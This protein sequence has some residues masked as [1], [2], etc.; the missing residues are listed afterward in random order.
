MRRIRAW[1][2][3]LSAMFRRERADHE[4]AAELDAHLQLHIEDNLR[5]GL[6]PAEAR[7]QALLALGGIET[8]K[9]AWRDRRGLPFLDTIAQD[10]RF[11]YRLLAKSPGFT[12]VAVCTLA[13]GIGANTAIFSVIDAVMLQSLPV[14]DPQHLFLL[15]W[16]AR[17]TPK[18]HGYSSYGDCASGDWH[19]RVEGCSLSRPFLDDVRNLGVFS[20]L[21]EFAGGN[22]VTLSGNGPATRVNAQFVSGDYFE[23]LGIAPAVGR[24]FVPSDDVPG[25]AAVAV[26]HYGYWQRQYGGDPSVVGRTVRLNG[27]PFTI[28]G[29]AEQR[30]T[31]F[32]PGKS[33]DL[34]VPLEQRQFLRPRWSPKQED[35]AS[36]WLVA[37]GRLKP[38]VSR[39]EAQQRISALFLNDLVHGDKPL[40]NPE[41][42]PAITLLPAQDA[43]TGVREDVSRMLFTLMLAVGLVLVIACANVAGLLLARSTARQKEIAV[44]L[45]LGAGRGRLLRQLLTESLALSAA[46]GALGI[47]LAY[48]AARALLAFAF[49]SSSHPPALSVALDWRVLGFTLLAAVLTGILFGLAP[50]LRAL[51]VQLTPALKDPGGRSSPTGRTF[52][53]RFTLGNGLVVAQV[54]LTMVVLVGAGL[55]VRTLRNLRNVDPGFATSNLLTFDVDTALTG[56]S[57]ERLAQFYSD[58]RDRFSAVPGVL[59]ASYAEDLLLAGWLSTTDFHLDGTPPKARSESDWLPI[60]PDYFATMKIPLLA[61]RNFLSEEYSTAARI[62]ADDKLEAQL[63]RATIVN[64]AFVRAYFPHVNPIGQRFGAETPEQSGDTETAPT[65]GFFIVGIAG[66]TKYRD[67]RREIKP[68]MYVP[69]GQGGSFELRTAG[70]P[71]AVMPAVREI[72]RQAG[73]DIPITEVKTQTQQIDELLLQER[74][75]ARLSALFGLLALLLACLGLHGLL[76]YEVTRRTRE[77]GIRMALGA[78]ARDVLRGVVARGLSL[79]VLGALLGA[80]VAAGVTRFLAAMLYGV[81]PNDAATLVAI[82]TILLLVALAACY[83]PARRATRVDPL[84]ALRYE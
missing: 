57:G 30:F 51:R 56:Y 62:A 10:L 67:L 22:G 50:A 17:A 35:P 52:R 60:G 6:S 21:A 19:N 53:S 65:A 61:G 63:A 7:R 70:D 44:R 38:G 31:F 71:L 47:L 32:T 74:L 34:W 36:W 58:L 8:T 84:V 46:G 4:F 45:A 1:L 9:E 13:L 12:A 27:R 24:M 80:A 15:H 5:R 76:A 28:I 81:K 37:V 73:N 42:A 72:V 59:S 41:D 54:A 2:N 33:R 26:L 40:L 66:D 25:A 43:M 75:I 20:G 48:W 82:V 18:T 23:T 3:R 11:A 14:R 29:V 49:S 55:L 68:T 39:L 64:Q 79:A 77:I 69:A 16:S 83:L 78:Q